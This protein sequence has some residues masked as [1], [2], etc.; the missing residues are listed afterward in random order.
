MLELKGL[1]KKYHVFPAVNKVSF[2]VGP[3]EILGYLGPNGAGKSTT[4]KILAGLLKPT[5]GEILF[6]GRN[7]NKNIYDFKKRLGYVPEESE[8]YP[9][10][11]AY[12]YLLLVGRLRRIPED[13]LHEKIIQFMKLFGLSEDMHAAISSFS[14]G[15]IQK[16]LITSALL[17]DP[18]IL[19]LDEPLSG[20]D[21]TTGLVIKDLLQKLAGEGK[22]IIYSSH[23]L[24]VVEKICT[25]VIIIHK[26]E[27]VADDSVENL[28][29]LMKLP[30]LE[31]IFSQLVVREDTRGIAQKMVA[32]MKTST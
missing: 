18:E 1:I 23:V 7:I 3:S 29:S 12:D 20:L 9:H 19:L 8:I 26:G 10:L 5:E 32:A 22:I 21:V 2:A 14:K 11:S 13:I 24:E 4:I 16:V 25:R 15:M 31:K 6:N 17:H 28:R 30:S 27:V